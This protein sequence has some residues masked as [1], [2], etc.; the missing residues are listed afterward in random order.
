MRNQDAPAPIERLPPEILADIFIRCVPV[1]IRRLQN[2]LRWLNLTQVNSHWRSVAL[3]CPEFWSTP[4][5]SRAASTPVFLER[6]KMAALVVRADANKLDRL[7]H[8]TASV[9]Q[10]VFDNVSRLGTLE[11]R[12]PQRRLTSTLLTL[13]LA[14]AAPRLQCLKVVNTTPTDGDGMWL[15]SI[16]FRRTET[17]PQTRSDLD[18]HLER[19]AF[20]WDSPWY[21]YLTHLHLEDIDWIQRPTMEAFLAILVG[22]PGLQTVSLIHSTPTTLDGFPVALPQL[23]ALTIRGDSGPCVQL[24]QYLIIP[25]S[26]TVSVS[27]NI[28]TLE[29]NTDLI[30]ALL[31]EFAGVSPTTYDTVR[32]I[33]KNGFAYYLLDSRRPWWS[34]RFRIEGKSCQPYDS[35]CFATRTLVETVDFSTVT[36]LHLHGMQGVLTN[37]TWCEAVSTL[38]WLSLGKRLRSVRTL[39]LH[40]TVPAA[41]LEFMLAQAMFVLGVTHFKFKTFALGFRDEHGMATHAWPRLQRL[42]LHG[43]DIGEHPPRW[44]PPLSVTRADLLRAL[45]WARRE[46]GAARIWQLEI[47]DCTNVLS[48][49]LQHF[50]L[51]AHV[52]WDGMGKVEAQRDDGNPCLRAYSLGV[53]ARMIERDK[54]DD[55]RS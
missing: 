26:A 7:P 45:M 24:L 16:L 34:R 54:D 35:L 46:S 41:W 13:Q 38:L 43:V 4:I 32:I 15:P 18:L 36:T 12:S 37:G 31:T 50:R 52:R 30:T 40:K 53:F 29:A 49:D 6:S 17:T 1:S 14:D 39:H 51:F 27:C 47:D 55:E 19:C 5:L 9:E 42:A 48:R 25:P 8:A 33:H 3:G 10:V 23:S 21:S 2:D 22:S 44:L 20:P 28:Q 11:L